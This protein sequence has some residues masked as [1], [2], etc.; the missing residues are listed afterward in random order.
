MTATG[1]IRENAAALTGLADRIWAYA[2]PSLREWRSALAT[3]ELLRAHGFTIAWGTA[4]LPAA[5]V[6]THGGRGPVLGF[7]VEPPYHLPPPEFLDETGQSPRPS[8]TPPVSAEPLG[9]I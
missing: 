4:G 5:F 9:K 2:E 8:R 7:N 3:A 1:W 6:A